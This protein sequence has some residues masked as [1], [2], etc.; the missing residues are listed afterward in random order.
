MASRSSGANLTARADR[1]LLEHRL[2]PLLGGRVAVDQIILERPVVELVSSEEESVAPTSGGELGDEGG[3]APAEEEGPA[4]ALAIDRFAIVDGTLT[5]RSVEPGA[6]E[7]TTEIRGLDLELSDIAVDPEAASLLQ[8]L[9]AAGEIAADE[10]VA[11]TVRAEKVRGDVRLAGGHLVIEDLDLPTAQRPLRVRELDA[12]LNVDP[13]TYSLA[14]AGEPLDTNLILGASEDGGF[15]LGRLSLEVTGDGSDDG[16]LAGAGT[17]SFAAGEMP[18]MPVLAAIERL[19]QG[20]EVI[21]AG[22][23]PFEIRFRIA[24]DR[25]EIDPFEIVMGQL[26][27]S[28]EGRIGLEGPLSLHAALSSP[29]QGIEVAE[30]P[31]EVLEALTDAEGR[32]NLPILISGSPEIPAIDFDRSGWSRMTQRRIESEVKKELSRELGKALGKLFG[33][34]DDDG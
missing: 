16:R 14:V 34:D 25:L 10:V 29:R 1:L 7:E 2:L 33:D 6:E 28:L 21:G 18:G 24:G 11:G 32:L 15:G 31:K 3:E 4:L 19:F 5:L 30:I 8:G 22:Y 26:A 13:Y 12:D 17:L 20:T 23:E 27:L 9:T